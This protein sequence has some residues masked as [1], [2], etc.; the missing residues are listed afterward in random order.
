MRLAT[1]GEATAFHTTG[2]VVSMMAPL[3]GITTVVLGG[4]LF[5]LMVTDGLVTLTLPQYK[6]TLWRV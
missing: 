5:T 1:P 4:G 3:A 6:A 2:L